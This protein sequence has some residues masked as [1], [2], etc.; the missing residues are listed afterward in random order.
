[1]IILC[2]EVQLPSI[3]WPSEELLFTTLSLPPIYSNPSPRFDSWWIWTPWKGTRKVEGG[4]GGRRTYER[5]DE[6]AALKWILCSLN[7]PVNWREKRNENFFMKWSDAAMM[8]FCKIISSLFTSGHGRPRILLAVKW[9]SAYFS[10]KIF[11]ATKLG[12]AWTS[13]FKPMLLNLFNQNTLQ[14]N[15]KTKKGGYIPCLSTTSLK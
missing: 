13:H 14:K 12:S 3:D 7:E 11:V 15:F 4:R 5:T 9:P 2:L 1:M 6:H 10:S 8:H